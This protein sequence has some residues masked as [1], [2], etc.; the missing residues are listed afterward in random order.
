MPKELAKTKGNSK[1]ENTNVLMKLRESLT[2]FS[3]KGTKL[4]IPEGIGR[5]PNNL[6]YMLAN[7]VSFILF[8]MLFGH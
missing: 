1:L 6:W 8:I 5:Y 7:L 3:E 4:T 2:D